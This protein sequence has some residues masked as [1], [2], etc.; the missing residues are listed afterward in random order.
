M[1]LD[2]LTRSEKKA[3]NELILAAESIDAD[4][5]FNADKRGLNEAMVRI[6]SH[7]VRFLLKS[8]EN[9]KALTAAAE[10]KS[11]AKH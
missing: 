3:L 7:R 9:L 5:S 8:L 6:E 4:L 10:K 11:H 1:K 2:N